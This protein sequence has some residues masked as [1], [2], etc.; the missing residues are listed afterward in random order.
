MIFWQVCINMSEISVYSIIRVNEKYLQML[1]GFNL[2][3]IAESTKPKILP[4]FYNLMR[5][6]I[7]V[8][9]HQ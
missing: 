1:L 7:E 4:K 2:N 5:G 6:C 8:E 3:G 9:Q